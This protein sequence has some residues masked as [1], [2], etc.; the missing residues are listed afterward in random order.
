MKIEAITVREIH[1][2]LVHF[3]ETSFGR[4]SSRRILLLTADCDGVNG[5][6]ECVAGEDPFYCSEWTE[7]AWLTITRAQPRFGTRLR[8]SFL[9]GA[10]SSHGKG[11]A[12]KC[13]MGCRG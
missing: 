9:A 4:T 5:W 10:R 8:G 2:P 11:R 12:G 6:A 1:M 13:S 7:S 3:F